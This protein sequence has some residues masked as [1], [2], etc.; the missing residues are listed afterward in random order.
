MPVAFTE[1]GTLITRNP[2][3]RGGRPILFDRFYGAQLGL[4]F[5]DF[6]I[7]RKT[8]VRSTWIAPGRVY[9]L[10]EVRQLLPRERP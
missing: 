1:I 6:E 9:R 3:L 4:S 7:F 8:I 10:D 2:T 5:G